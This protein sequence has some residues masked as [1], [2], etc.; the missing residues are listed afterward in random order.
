MLRG[1]GSETQWRGQRDT[2]RWRLRALVIAS[3]LLHV[4]LSPLG[5]LLGLVQLIGPQSDTM[6]VADLNAVTAIPVDLVEDEDQ[7][8]STPEPEPTPTA[9]SVSR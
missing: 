8:T 7:G 2:G 5:A 3:A 9:A 6:G 4:P 1:V